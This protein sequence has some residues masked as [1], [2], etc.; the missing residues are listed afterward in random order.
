MTG[1]IETV[2]AAVVAI[3]LAGLVVTMIRGACAKPALPT[4]DNAAAAADRA[5]TIR[6]EQ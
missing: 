1:V 4:R 5:P 2:L 6:D 3:L